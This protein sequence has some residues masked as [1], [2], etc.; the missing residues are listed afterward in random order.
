MKKPT[1]T[2]EKAK[3]PPPCSNYYYV[4]HSVPTAGAGHENLL[5]TGVACTQLTIVLASYPKWWH[6]IDGFWVIGTNE[7]MAQVRERLAIF[8]PPKGFFVFI[9]LFTGVPGDY[10]GFMP[11]AAWQYLSTCKP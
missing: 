5:N 8:I 4:A 3:A 1:G 10:N 6:Y 11:E 9:G 2:T 7:T